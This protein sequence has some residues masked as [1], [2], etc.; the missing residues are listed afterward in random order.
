[1]VQNCLYVTSVIMTV[2]SCMDALRVPLAP[3]GKCCKVFCALAVR[4]DA[5]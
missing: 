1:M 2:H 3:P 5:E 4:S